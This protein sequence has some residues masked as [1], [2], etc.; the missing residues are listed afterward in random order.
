GGARAGAGRGRGPG[1]HRHRALVSGT[2]AAVIDPREAEQALALV[3]ERARGYGGGL[4]ERPVRSETVEEDAASF[5]GPLP[6]EGDGTLA[7]LTALLERGPDAAIASS[8]PRL[9][10]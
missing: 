10:R 4:A 5:G 2:W 3:A 6:E 1:P 8:G 7:A 9:D